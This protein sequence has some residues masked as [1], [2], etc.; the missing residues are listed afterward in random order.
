MKLQHI[1]KTLPLLAGM[2]LGA[3]SCDYIHEDLEPC[4]H[5]LHFSYTYNMKQADAF[6]PEMTNQ[7]TAK[8]VELFIYD[9][10]GKFLSSQTVSGAELE[11]NQVKLDLQPGTYQLLAWAGLNETDYTWTKPTADASLADWQMAVKETDGEVSR[12]LLGLFQGSLKLEIPAGGETDN[13]LPMVKNTNKIRLVLIDAN[14]GTELKAEDF[15]ISATTQNGDLDYA[16]QPISTETLTWQPYYQA[17]ESVQSADGSITY[18]AVCAELNTLRL[19]DDSQTSLS[20]RYAK[21]DEEPF[22][23]VNLTDLLLLTKME[24]HDMEAQEYLDRQDEYVI[25]A[26]LDMVGGKAHCL[27][28]LVNDWTIRLDDVNLAREAR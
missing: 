10:E 15:A 22:L 13:T 9:A 1:F 11:A 23:H 28:I 5:F 2:M 24:S 14:G 16:N 19:L 27:E 18:Q 8:Q 7:A 12:E 4:D 21:E 25:T 3:A 20:L 6:V 26:Y 17:V